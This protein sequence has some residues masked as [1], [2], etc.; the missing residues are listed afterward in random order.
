MTIL[1]NNNNIP[2]NFTGPK[3]LGIDSNGYLDY[4]DLPS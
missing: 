2:T 3:Y 1:A 4:Y